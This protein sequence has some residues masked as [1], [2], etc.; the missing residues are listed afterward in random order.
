MSPYESLLQPWYNPL[1]LIGFNHHHH[2]SL[3]REGRWGTTDN[4]ATSFLNFSLFS[5][6]L[7]DLPNSR[8]VHSLKL[9][10]H[11][12]LCLPRLLPP[13][14][15]QDGFGQTWWTGNMT[16]PLQFASLY[17]RQEV[18]AWSNCLLDVG[19]DFLVEEETTSPWVNFTYLTNN[20][21]H[22]LEMPVWT[23]QTIESVPCRW[24][25]KSNT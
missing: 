21:I 17:D 22:W 6:A 5:I 10:S 18:F 16:I 7:W 1:W 4:F 3:N 14:T 19:T 2:Q 15:V 12:F 8:P 20:W 25:D 11:L 13:L 9:S 24:K 23:L